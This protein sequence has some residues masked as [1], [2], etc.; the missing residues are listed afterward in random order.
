MN[1]IY[2]SRVVDGIWNSI[3]PNMQQLKLMG[4]TIEV[5]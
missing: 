5:F 1:I 3:L 2:T 4:L